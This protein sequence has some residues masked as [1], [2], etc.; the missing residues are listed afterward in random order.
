VPTAAPELAEVDDG[1]VEAQ[2][3]RA[4]PSSLDPLE[5]VGL[6]RN[7]ETGR[8]GLGSIR[9]CIIAGEVSVE[10]KPSESGLG[11]LME[12]LL[13]GLLAAPQSVRVPR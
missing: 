2:T 3:L 5:E 4:T 12:A 7:E 1:R 10:E 6:A 13:G 11:R 8:V 9:T